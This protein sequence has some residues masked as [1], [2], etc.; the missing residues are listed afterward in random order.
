MRND[1]ET[2]TMS[3]DL[4][5]SNPICKTEQVY[6]LGGAVFSLKNCDPAYEAALERLLPHYHGSVPDDR[7]HLDTG[8][9]KD[10][11]VL[12]RHMATF[13]HQRNCVWIEASCLVSPENQ[14]VL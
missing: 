9:S 7:C 3:I 6:Q 13:H 5:T 12:I 10:V 1:E 11:P 14:K 2:A 4:Q 8:C